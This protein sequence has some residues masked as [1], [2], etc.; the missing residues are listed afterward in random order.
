MRHQVPAEK[1]RDGSAILKE[2]VLLKSFPPY[3]VLTIPVK[4]MRDAS[5]NGM[6]GCHSLHQSNHFCKFCRHFN[7]HFSW[8]LLVDFRNIQKFLWQHWIF[9]NKGDTF[10]FHI[11]IWK[12]KGPSLPL[13]ILERKTGA[14]VLKGYNI[15]K[16]LA[17]PLLNDN[18]GLMSY[19]Q[20]HTQ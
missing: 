19:K 6:V 1:Q 14:V 15:P 9:L 7:K 3:Y 13:E 5:V 20:A 18:A 8:S 10:P 16:L 4:V 2:T 11:L 12:D 17:K